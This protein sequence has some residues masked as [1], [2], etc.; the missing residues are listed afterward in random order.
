MTA[1]VQ[2]GNLADVMLAYIQQSRGASLTLPREWY[3]RI[4][5]MST[6]L[7]YKRRYT[8]TGVGTQSARKTFFDSEKDGRISIEQYFLKGKVYF[9]NIVSCGI[10]DRSITVYKIK[11]KHADDLPVI[12]VGNKKRTYL[13]AE[14]C[15]IE[16]GQAYRGK[17]SDVQTAEMIR[18]ACNPPGVN[19]VSI[20]E[21]GFEKLGLQPPT[22]PSADFGVSV[23]NEMAVIPARE[24]P[25]PQLNYRSGQARVAN[26]AWNIVNTKFHLGAQ[27]PSWAVMVVQEPGKGPFSGPQ[28]PELG[29]IWGVFARKMQT[30]G[31]T[32]GGDPVILLAK[33]VHPAEDPGRM[34]SLDAIRT[35]L[36][37]HPKGRKPAFVLVLLSQRDNFIYPGIKVSQKIFFLESC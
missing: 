24:L 9:V 11:L 19:A 34:R 32:V 36:R 17:L 29:R 25:P 37:S 26:G 1:F 13:P 21:A 5:V 10:I 12:D 20:V 15:T 6:H 3:K 22:S 2:P 7:G 23:S 16:P 4:K 30:S 31:M 35:V 14:L 8:L 28:D 18:Y 27:V 33:L